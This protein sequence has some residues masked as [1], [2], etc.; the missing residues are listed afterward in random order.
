MRIQNRNLNEFITNNI[1][2]KKKY[3]L[4]IGETPSSGARSPKLWNKVYRKYKI[5]IKMFPADVQ[6][7]NLSPLMNYLKLD[8]S[9]IGSAITTPYKELILNYIDFFSSEVHII[10]SINTLKKMNKKLEGYN[11]DYFGA[12]NS[13]SLFEKKKNI[14]VFGCGGAGKAVILAST[15]KF[16]NAFFYFFN[17][18]KK[19]L[20]L[21]IKKLKIKN[22][23]IVDYEKILSLRNID[24][25]INTTSIGFNSWILRNKKF[26]NLIHFTPFTNLKKI[27]GTRSKNKKEFFKKNHELIRQDKLNYLNFLEQNSNCEFFD[28]IYNPSMTKLLKLAK[29]NNHKILNGLKMNLDQAVKAFCI[30]NN[31]EFKKTNIL[32]KK[33]G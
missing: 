2:K 8:D 23:K 14:L 18:D 31:K 4:I 6:K 7:K 9:F 22:F 24:L 21:F 19:K 29:V 15:K 32:M 30:V 12:I 3:A 25:V 5:K 20:R 28:I 13:L 10:G 11:T 27:R 26:Y 16:N 1:F 33:N 17:R